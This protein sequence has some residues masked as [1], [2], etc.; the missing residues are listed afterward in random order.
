MGPTVTTAR[1]IQRAYRA[2]HVLF[3]TASTLFQQELFCVRT[4]LRI[5]AAAATPVSPVVWLVVRVH[6]FD[7][8]WLVI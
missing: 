8:N 1:A 5:V 4:V 3:V 2:Q 7:L 6:L